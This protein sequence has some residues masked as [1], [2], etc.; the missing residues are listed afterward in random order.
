MEAECVKIQK[1][2]FDARLHS[3]DKPEAIN[4]AKSLPLASSSDITAVKLSN[5]SDVSL[6]GKD[7]T[8]D[9]IVCEHIRDL[10]DRGYQAYAAYLTNGPESKPRTPPPPEPCKS[11][12]NVSLSSRSRKNNNRLFKRRRRRS[13]HRNHP[14][15]H[16][17][18]LP[19]RPGRKKMLDSFSDDDDDDANDD[20]TPLQ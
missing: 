6:S 17:M 7:V 13:R 8:Y 11:S 10:N 18:T 9:Y 4:H 14:A 15:A 12:A 3:R 20:T 16:R 2:S 1:P 19:T 5:F